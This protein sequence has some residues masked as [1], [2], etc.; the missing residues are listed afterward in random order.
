MASYWADIC[1]RYPVVSIED[2][3]DE[4][5][6]DGW[7]LLTDKLGEKVQLVGDD[8]FV[9][10]PERLQPRDRARRRQLDPR[11]GQPDRDPDRDPGGDPDRRATPATAP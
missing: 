1:S 7:K 5:D 8:L 2:G 6:W 11:Q 9:T 10:N 3:M 4:E